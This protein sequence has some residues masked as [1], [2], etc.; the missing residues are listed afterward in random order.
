MRKILY[1]F[2]LILTSV[3][4]L[5]FSIVELNAASNDLYTWNDFTDTQNGLTISI[6]EASQVITLNGT[7]TSLF[8]FNTMT[9]KNA[10]GTTVSILDSTKEY[11]IH[12]EYISGTTNNRFYAIELYNGV[13]TYSYVGDAGIEKQATTYMVDQ[14]MV[15][16]PGNID[17]ISINSG[18]S[19][20]TFDN[21]KYKIHIYEYDTSST[22]NLFESDYSTTNSSISIAISNNN[23][24]VIN[25]S[26][27]LSAYTKVDLTSALNTALDPA[28]EYLFKYEYI[29]GTLESTA[30][31]TTGNF[32]PITLTYSYD[33]TNSVGANVSRNHYD[34][35]THFA[36]E[37]SG[38]LFANGDISEVA[39]VLSN[40][41][42]Q[43][44]TY[45]NLTYKIHVEE[46]GASTPTDPVDGYDITDWIQTDGYLVYDIANNLP[47][48]V[49]D[50]A[51][52]Y[53]NPLYDVTDYEYATTSALTHQA[54]PADTTGIKLIQ[55]IDASMTVQYQ[56]VFHPSDQIIIIS[57]TNPDAAWN[58]IS[59]RLAVTP[60][61][62]NY[63]VDG[64]VDS[65][66]NST[67]GE[68]LI[69]PTDPILSGYTFIGWYLEDTYITL[70]DFSTDTIASETFNLY[71]RFVADT[72]D[73]FTVSFE[74]NGGSLV[75]DR[76]VVSGESI[77]APVAPTRSG[78]TFNGWFTDV[79]LTTAYDF[80]SLVSADAT[81]YAKWTESTTTPVTPS[82]SALGVVEWVFISLGA[83][84]VAYAV[85]VGKKK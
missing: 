70:F 7:N 66:V 12:Y 53:F 73:V 23:T 54:V 78:Y 51:S 39:L 37:L 3:A 48:A 24:I 80:T 27:L 2:L 42:S 22:I 69:K 16:N 81:L 71:A 61:V 28:K 50:I 84:A 30:S 9:L 5:S 1:L 85:F 52:I 58:D 20:I 55:T 62:V 59:I 34:Y 76:L 57:E 47:T 13:S 25:G 33:G 29:S 6:D 49:D 77:D 32:I 65:T 14:S 72:T 38:A 17:F 56:I 11:I 35:T 67:V 44:V 36:Y 63:Y 19:N 18:V 4:A 10:L 79:E 8:D 41:T 83:A 46:I 26:S 68:K 75:D 43:T 45:T 40:A 60:A 64:V 15:L 21:L 82:E 31:Q 74:E